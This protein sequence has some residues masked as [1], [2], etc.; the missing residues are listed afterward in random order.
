M[1]VEKEIIMEKKY[2]RIAV[3]LKKGEKASLKVLADED[4]RTV[5]GYIRALIRQD[6]IAEFQDRETDF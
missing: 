2:E 1:I 6:I 3:F 4:G 5:S